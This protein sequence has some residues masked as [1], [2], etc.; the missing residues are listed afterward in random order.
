[1]VCGGE[2]GELVEDGGEEVGVGVLGGLG[3]DFFVVEVDGYV[4]G[5]VVVEGGGRGCGG[6]EVYDGVV[7]YVEVVEM[8]GEDEFVVEIV[9]VG[10]LSVV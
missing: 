8:W 2:N 1:M 6:D 9:D 10:F 5:G 7:C 3:V 4:D